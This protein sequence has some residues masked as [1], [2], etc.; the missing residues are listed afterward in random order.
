MKRQ[1][2]QNH[3]YAPQN[4]SGADD[5]V[6]ENGKYWNILSYFIRARYDD[7]FMLVPKLSCS[8][9]EATGI[10]QHR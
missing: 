8:A 7:L 9:H 1:L 4:F 5:I 3:Q 10:N 6:R 2:T